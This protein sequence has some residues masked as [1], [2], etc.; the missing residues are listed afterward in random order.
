MKGGDERENC[1]TCCCG[2]GPFPSFGLRGSPGADT[3][4]NIFSIPEKRGAAGLR[5]TRDAAHPQK[6]VTSFFG[7]SAYGFLG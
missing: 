5:R 7:I 4:L 1:E 2:M 6:V 3:R